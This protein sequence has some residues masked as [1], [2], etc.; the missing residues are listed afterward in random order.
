MSPNEPVKTGEAAMFKRIL[1]AIAR[2]SGGCAGRSMRRQ[3]W[4]PIS[5][6]C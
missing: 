4:L 1:V 5:V 6:P 2:E 3:S